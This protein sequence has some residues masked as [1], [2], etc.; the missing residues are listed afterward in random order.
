ME[1]GEIDLVCDFHVAFLAGRLVTRELLQ[2]GRPTK[3]YSSYYHDHEAITSLCQ[4]PSD[5]NVAPPQLFPGNPK[6]RA[7]LCTHTP[8][9]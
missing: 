1:R 2:S 6:A 7:G 9:P 3:A 4:P 8:N 5:P